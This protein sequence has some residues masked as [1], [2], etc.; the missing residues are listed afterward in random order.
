V[1][2]AIGVERVK[3]VGRTNCVVK[4]KRRVPKKRCRRIGVRGGA[5]EGGHEERGKTTLTQYEIIV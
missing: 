4:R 1:F 5:V 2:L 3:L